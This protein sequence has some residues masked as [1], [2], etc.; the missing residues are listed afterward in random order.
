MESKNIKKICSFSVSNWHLITM[1]VP[2]LTKQMQEEHQICTFFET[3][4]EELV[5]EFL[6]KLTLNETSKQKL[7]TIYWNSNLGHKYTQIS[8]VLNKFQNKE[9]MIIVNGNKS[10]IEKVNINIDKWI[11]KNKI[12]SK[13]K[14]LNCYEVLQFNNNIKEILDS[15]DSILNTSGER[16]IAEVFEGYTKNKREAI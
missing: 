15:H 8:D 13:I 7:K 5:D 14:I 12:T 9:I 16:E 1:I 3:N 2:Y 4:M 11:K 10:Y 6:S